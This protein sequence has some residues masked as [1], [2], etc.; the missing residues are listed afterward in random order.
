MLLSLPDHFGHIKR[1]ISEAGIQIG[2]LEYLGKLYLR[3][4]RQITGSSIFEDDWDLLV[5]LDA[6][7]SDAIERFKGSYTFLSEP[8]TRTSVGS[9]TPEWL[10]KTFADGPED[11]LADLA[12]ITGNPHSA[13]HLDE[14]ILGELDDVWRYAWDDE[15][16]TV[17]ARPITDRAI[18]TGRAEEFD[19]M[20]VHYMQ[21]HFPSVPSPLENGGIDLET[22][23]E[24]WSSVWD[25]LKRGTITKETAWEAYVDNLEYVLDDV[26][27]LLE[28][29][30]AEAVVITSDHGNA[31]GECWQYGH[32]AGVALNCLRV[33]PWYETSA[34][35]RGTH[36][37]RD[38]AD[39]ET[40]SM[41]DRLRA[42]GYKN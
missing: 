35:D 27:L 18:A 3:K 28:N 34:T 30:D 31:F 6:C 36:E 16:G 32:P 33:V 4:G 7:R 2:S 13:Y 25:E 15:L 9:A 11:T 38:Y 26:T 29:V 19:R 39:S 37:H 20:I 5:V 40:L 42:L 21:P 10:E 17:R 14:S 1:H 8:D 23:G 12:Y 24:E 22:F 41:E